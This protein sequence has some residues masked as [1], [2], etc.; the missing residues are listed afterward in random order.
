MEMRRLGR[1]GPEVSALAFGCGRLSMKQPGSAEQGVAAV[2]AA[3]DAGMNFLD[4]ADFY[5]MGD[6]ETLIGRAL[7]GRREQAFLSVKFGLMLSP[8]GAFLGLEGRPNSIKNFA[9]YSLQRLGVEVIDLY[10]PGRPDPSVPYEE[11]IGAIKDL[12]QEGKV[13]YLGV[14]EVGADLL[15]R[16]HAVHPVTALEIE[17]SLGCRFIEKEILPVARELGIGVVPYR[18]LADGLLTGTVKSE[19]SGRLVAPRLQGDNLKHNLEVVKALE[20]MAAAKSVTP[21]Q[22]AVA[23]VLTRGSDVTPQVG[24]ARPERLADNLAALDVRWSPDEL[25]ALDRVFAPGAIQ[26]DRYPAFVMK[27]AAN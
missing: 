14:S 3:L 22:L 4:T 23:W 27:Y 21:A 12:I 17:Y 5:G 2:Q 18:V 9:S 7:K 26:G 8:S 15:R 10:Q 20:Q 19:P 11:T 25:A 1:N 24:M 6:S 13:R 16:A